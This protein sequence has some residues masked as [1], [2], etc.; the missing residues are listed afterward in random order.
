MVE[1]EVGTEL[2]VGSELAGA[3]LLDDS[4]EVG[5]VDDAAAVADEPAAVE[6]LV[7]AAGKGTTVKVVKRV[8]PGYEVAAAPE[9]TVIVDTVVD[10]EQLL[11]VTV[12][13]F[14]AVAG[15]ERR[16]MAIKAV[17]NKV[18]IFICPDYRDKLEIYRLK[19]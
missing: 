10:P 1:T 16:R 8:S 13:F 18:H 15:S 3:E 14:T 11:T 2:L 7:W 12:R 9:V 4:K 6:A 17:G 5:I 19:S